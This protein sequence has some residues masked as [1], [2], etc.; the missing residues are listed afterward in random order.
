VRPE[1]AAADPPALVARAEYA[2]VHERSRRAAAIASDD[3]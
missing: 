3:A 1:K 2:R